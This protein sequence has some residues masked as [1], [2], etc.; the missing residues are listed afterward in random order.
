MDGKFHLPAKRKEYVRNSAPVRVTTE[1]Y[2]ILVEMYN[3]CNL[4]MSQIASKAIKFA[5]DNAVY[6]KEDIIDE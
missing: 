4:S 6:D 3:E 1:A 2:N 5:Y